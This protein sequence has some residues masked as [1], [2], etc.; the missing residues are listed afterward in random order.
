MLFCRRLK[1]TVFDAQATTAT[2]RR[3]AIPLINLHLNRSIL[4]SLSSMKKA[5]IPMQILSIFGLEET[6]YLFQAQK[7]DSM[8]AGAFL[9][10]SNKRKDARM[11][12]ISVTSSSPTIT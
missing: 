11:H 3:D 5:L 6:S 1:A 2:L 4:G 12:G 7:W 9:A 10:L 8:M